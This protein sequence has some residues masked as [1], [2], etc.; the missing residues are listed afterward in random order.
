MKCSL[1]GHY[2]DT[3]SAVPDGMEGFG[4]CN[5]IWP[6]TLSSKRHGCAV[7]AQSNRLAR[8]QISA[9]RLITQGA[10]TSAW[11]LSGRADL[12]PPSWLALR[13]Q[14]HSDAA[15]L[16]PPRRHSEF[17]KRPNGRPLL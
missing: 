6:G 13:R 2:G 1:I 12:V 11:D 17:R 15:Y 5:S 16:W 4:R 3:H 10:L 7:G 8:T 9:D 14:T